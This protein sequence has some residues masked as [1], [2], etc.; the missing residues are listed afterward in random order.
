MVKNATHVVQILHLLHRY[1]GYTV[2]LVASSYTG[3]PLDLVE[4]C[5]VD[6]ILP[7][8]WLSS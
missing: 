7:D 8:G 5:L 6:V 1:R 2:P 3:Q 4:V